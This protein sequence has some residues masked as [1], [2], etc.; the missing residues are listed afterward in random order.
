MALRDKG[1]KPKIRANMRSLERLGAWISTRPEGTVFK[2]TKSRRHRKGTCSYVMVGDTY[3]GGAKFV[4][5]PHTGELC[6][7]FGT[8][9]RDNRMWTSPVVSARRAPRKEDVWFIK[10]FNSVYKL[11][12]FA[13][14]KA[15]D[16]AQEDAMGVDGR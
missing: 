2:A 7:S 4:D 15:A 16:G 13:V 1:R 12:I 11:E 6:M 10:T 14:N 8:G 5:H 3:I 9:M